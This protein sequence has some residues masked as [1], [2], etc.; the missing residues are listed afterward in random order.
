M[1]AT[2]IQTDGVGL[3]QRATSLTGLFVMVAIA[4]ALS[5]NRK[6]IR[7]KPVIWGI[8]L[9]LLFGLIV[10]QHGGPVPPASGLF[11]LRPYR[12]LSPFPAGHEIHCRPRSWSVCHTVLR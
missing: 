9:Q 7:W 3:A 10:L 5:L 4:Y 11:G 2:F 6:A 12:C 8:G 1:L